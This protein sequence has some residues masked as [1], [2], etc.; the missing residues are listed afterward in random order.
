MLAYP[1]T[2]MTPV[3][4][5]LSEYLSEESKR[6]EDQPEE[7]HYTIKYYKDA[8]HTEPY[9]DILEAASGKYVYYDLV[10]DA[11]YYVKW[12]GINAEYMDKEKILFGK[13]APAEPEVNCV[14]IGDVN[15]DYKTN[16]SDVVLLMRLMVV[17]Y[18]DYSAEMT[19]ADYNGDGKFNLLDCAML[20]KYIAKWDV[21]MK[22]ESLEEPEIYCQFASGKVTEFSRLS[23]YA[24]FY[25]TT[26]VRSTEELE[27]YI[28]EYSDV[29]GMS[30]KIENGF[31]AD[32][33]R[34]AYGE[35]FFVGNELVIFDFSDSI[36]SG[37]VYVENVDNT[38]RLAVRNYRK[39][40]IPY[41]GKTVF[42]KLTVVPK[43]LGIDLDAG[44]EICTRDANTV[45]ARYL[46]KVIDKAVD[47]KYINSDEVMKSLK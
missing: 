28:E 30:V 6:L 7:Q 19:V 15:S 4:Y 13:Y 17:E 24:H 39:T 26:V 27:D 16:L 36:A 21:D 45:G 31:Y 20:L 8:E 10:C 18:Y 9:A 1:S 40:G 3:V 43:D 29:Y 25:N 34:A 5:Y 35:E 37:D 44:I 11:E 41:D 2:A 47:E 12:I 46:R 23:R 14:R 32:D 33:L 22:G 42:H 38:L